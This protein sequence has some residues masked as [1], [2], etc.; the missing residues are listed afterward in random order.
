MI[1]NFGNSFNLDRKLFRQEI[2]AAVAHCNGL[3][4]C[5]ILTRIEAER[6]KNGLWTVLK[7]AD[8]DR[9]FFDSEPDSDVFAFVESRL[10]QLVSHAADAI[11]IG[12]DRPTQR[13]VALRL[14]LREEL[15]GISET[16]ENVI[17]VLHQQRENAVSQSLADGLLRD[18]ARFSEILPRINQMPQS[19]FALHD[20]TTAELDFELIA[21]ELDFQ[22]SAQNSSDEASDADFCIECAAAAALCVLHLSS[23]A[24]QLLR[25]SDLSINKQQKFAI[26]RA[27]ANR[28]FANHHALLTLISDS[29]AEGSRV[30]ENAADFNEIC[31]VVFD[32]CDTL[33]TCLEITL[34]N[35]K[36]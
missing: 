12:R 13:R 14:W 19:D 2:R 26:V 16:V 15:A 31:E 36:N 3:F 7:R 21:H 30:F 34:I 8:F 4:R 9:H 24:K 25:R 5:G 17:E 28:V 22:N 11:K 33:K 10:F 27:K 32:V 20:E 23:F 6:L 35:H 18:A 1:S 29:A